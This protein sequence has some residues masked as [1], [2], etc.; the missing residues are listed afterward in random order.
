MPNV[1][2]GFPK[3]EVINESTHAF[4]TSFYITTLASSLV[5][6]G[7]ENSVCKGTNFTMPFYPHSMSSINKKDS[8]SLDIK[9]EIILLNICKYIYLK[10]QYISFKL[11]KKYK[12]PISNVYK[13]VHWHTSLIDVCNGVVDWAVK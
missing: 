8:P 7:I 11:E 2:F 6:I 12:K 3:K 10:I 4:I 1:P 9:R 5:L 13:D